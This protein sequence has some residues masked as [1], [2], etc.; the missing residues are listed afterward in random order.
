MSVVTR[1][2]GRF[3]YLVT[4]GLSGSAGAGIIVCPLRADISSSDALSGSVVVDASLS[5]NVSEASLS[6]S[7]Q[8]SDAL[9]SDATIN[10][11][12]SGDV[13]FDQCP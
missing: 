8:Q 5:G 9:S 2:L 10:D 11:A 4:R 3:G 13:E 1:G 6:A 7:V 12:L